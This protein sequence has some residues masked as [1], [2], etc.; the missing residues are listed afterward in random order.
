MLTLFTGL[1]GAGKTLNLIKQVL[2]NEQFQNRN[3]YYFGINGL[4]IPE[5]TELS[6]DQLHKW[7]E[8]TDSPVILIDEVQ[9]VWRKR[10]ASAQIPYDIQQLETHRHLGVDFLMT[11][12]NP[13]QIDHE[14]RAM[15]QQH[16]HYDRVSNLQSGRRYEFERC[17]SDP[18][19]EKHLAVQTSRYKIDKKYFEYYKSAEL[20]T[21]G[22]RIPKK[23]YIAIAAVVVCLLFI[24]YAFKSVVLDRGGAEPVLMSP[25]QPGQQMEVK[26]TD[27]YMDKFVSRNNY[28]PFSQPFYDELVRPRSYPHITG[29]INFKVNG[30]NDCRCTSIQGNYVNVPENMC[31]SFIENGQ[32]DF[33]V[34]DEEYIQAMY[35]YL[36][37]G[38]PCCGSGSHNSEESETTA[39]TKI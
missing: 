16:W 28:V 34:P 5:W 21:H 14:V 26:S 36:P 23:L 33:T 37:T 25:Q 3:I 30:A 17:I 2:S 4:N 8:M 29:C 20:H 24:G 19:K 9:K 15:I 1:P 32:H 39:N 18:Y 27:T 22:R 12:Q 38:E 7:Y 35:K 11:C 10:G 6:E 13:M 31:L